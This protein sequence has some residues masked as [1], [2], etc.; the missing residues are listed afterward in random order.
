[1]AMWL[2]AVSVPVLLAGRE[3]DD[4]AGADLLDQA[5]LALAAAQAGDHDQRLAERVRVPG[6]APG[7]KVTVAPPTRAGASALNGASRRTAPMK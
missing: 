7:S 3:P 5:P 1:M 6:G 4:V 2:I